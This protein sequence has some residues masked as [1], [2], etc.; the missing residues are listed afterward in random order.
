MVFDNTGKPIAMSQRE[1]K[2]ICPQ[3][4][5]V[6]HDPLEIW[7]NTK[8]VI[9]DAVAKAGCRPADI[10][11][12]GITNQRET[13]VVWDSRTGA[14]LHN[15]LVWMDVRTGA[16]VN[17]L[18]A[19]HG[20]QDAFRGVTGLPLS[21]YFSGLKIKWL[22]DNVKAVRNAVDGHHAL[23]GTIDTW[24]AWNL[25]GG[26]SGGAHVTD[27]TNASRT[28]LMNIENLSW[29]QRMCD[30]LGVPSDMLP[31]ICS[32]SEVYGHTVA[33]GPFG[34]NLPVAGIVGDQQAACVGQACLAQGDVKNTY[35]T[36][37]FMLLNTGTR[38][39]YS[40]NGLL[41]TVCYKF[42]SK[43]AVYA[44]EG[45][46]A[47]AGALVQ[48]LRDNLKII[49]SSSE[50]EK[51]ARTVEDNG[52]VYFVPAFSGLYAPHW[53]QDARGI[54]AGLTRFANSGHIARAAL[55]ATAFQTRDVLDAMT[56]DSGVRPTSLKVDGGMVVNELL[57][58]FQ[59]DLLGIPVIRPQVIETTALGAA[60]AAGL[61]VGLWS[62]EA[63]ICAHWAENKRWLP[64]AASNAGKD[65]YQKWKKAVTRT[66][67]WA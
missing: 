6:E 23:F 46:V 14:P 64:N 53:R 7:E 66:L 36:G 63:E 47:I 9:K 12:V 25:T 37:C 13:T 51:L 55:E 62:S 30:A 2:Q 39:K 33:N 44:L 20:S 57:M 65:L 56:A 42:G 11:G 4:G 18:I 48:W 49:G 52:D 38:P 27:A 61:G 54:I 16:L 35:G 3:P 26:T 29:D 28:M 19:K 24:L 22:I 58:Q 41:T 21:T 5:W 31:R 1:H 59:A 50:I 15:A 34:A 32:S 17:G 10:A 43:P 67:E 45:S 8:L 40:K 60:Y